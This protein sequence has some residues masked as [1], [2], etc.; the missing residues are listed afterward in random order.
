MKEKLGLVLEMTRSVE[1]VI[2]EAAVQFKGG[3]ARLQE[4]RDLSRQRMDAAK[5]SLTGLRKEL[6][7]VTAKANDLES[8]NAVLRKE[9]ETSSLTHAEIGT[10][11]VKDLDEVRDELVKKTGECN[12]LEPKVVELEKQQATLHGVARETKRKK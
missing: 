2:A 12:A 4:D 5:I 6:S 10:G 8:A 11:R 9:L 7:V 1:A 3:L